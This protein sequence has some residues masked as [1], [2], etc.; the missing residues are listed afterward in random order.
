MRGQRPNRMGWWH[1]VTVRKTCIVLSIVA[2]VD[3]VDAELD[4]AVHVKEGGAE[5]AERIARKHGMEN[6]GEVR[7]K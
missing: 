1:W 5:A 7:I 2:I 4:F 3:L 6:M